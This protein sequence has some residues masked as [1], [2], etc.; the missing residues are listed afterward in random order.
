M[1][2]LNRRARGRR[3]A[4]RRLLAIWGPGRDRRLPRVE[5]DIAKAIAGRGFADLAE[6][7]RAIIELDGT[8]NKARLGANAL[9]AVSQAVACALADQAGQP[10]HQ[11]L[12][13]Q[14]GVPARLP[15]PTST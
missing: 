2:R 8:P 12:S 6:L 7:D 14:I 10:L 11:Y 3:A 9:L 1:R 4:R 5:T 15:V 13:E